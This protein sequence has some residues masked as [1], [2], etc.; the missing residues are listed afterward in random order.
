MVQFSGLAVAALLSGA[1][2]AAP[3]LQER[4]SCTFSGSSAAS[5]A[6][7][8]KKSCSNIIIKD[9][10]VPAGTTLDLTNLASGTTVTFEGTTTFGYKEWK[11]PLVSVSG[12][13]ITVVGASGSVIDG[14]GSRWWDGKGTN[15]GKTKPKFFYAHSMTNS[16]IQNIKIKNSPV[17]VFSINNSKQ[18]TLTGVTVDNSAG[19]GDNKGHNT[20]AFDIGSSSGI[21]IDGANIHNQDDCVA[22]NSGSD[23]TVSG[24]TCTGG[25]GLSIGSVG[26]RDD[27]T[28]SDVKFLNNKVTNSQ[29]GLRIKTV[30]G[31]T[32]KVSGVTYSGNVLS[33]ITKYGVVIE[34]DYE[35]GSPTGKPTNG[36]PI[37]GLTMTDNTVGV[38]SSGTNTYIL[39][40]SGAC[41]NWKWSG[42][43][44]SG[45]KKSSKCSGIPSGSG[46]SC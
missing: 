37:T 36:V 31:A 10:V 43:K 1:A 39:C 40:A 23:I 32:G 18:L 26:G 22:V 8:Q 38:S 29:N 28:V 20:D 7:K 25:H 6:L 11:G 21:T 33:G 13:H 44:I 17:Q 2:I 19:D 41:S 9:A 16:K 35:N 45:G 34:Q 4:G 5:N 42:N 30:Y 14:D 12:D 27:N 46:A 24:S 3:T 15:G